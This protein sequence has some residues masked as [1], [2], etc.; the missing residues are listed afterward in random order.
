VLNQLYWV[1]GC[2]AG[3]LLGTTLPFNTQGIDFVMTALF[4]ITVLGQ[5]S[6]PANRSPALI[7][8][9]ISI[10]C[11]LLFGPQWFIIAAMAVMIAIFGVTKNTLGQRMNNP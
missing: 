3:G 9:S 1:V 5:W 6:N 8:F 2:T 4:T 7:G 11:R 10:F